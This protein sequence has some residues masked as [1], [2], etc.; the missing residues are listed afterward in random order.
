LFATRMLIL[1]VGPKGA[2]KSHIGRLLERSLDTRFFHVEPL[3]M[4][5]HATCRAQGREPIIPEGIARVHPFIEAALATHPRVSVETTGG[6]AEI[7]EDLMRIGR[8][9]GL[10]LARIAAPVE[11][12]LTRIEARDPTHQIPMD[13]SMIRKVHEIASA[14]DLPFDLTI[15]NTAAGETEILDAFR[16]AIED[17]GDARQ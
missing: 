17:R 1:L 3:W 15:D 4:D 2:G 11:T 8:R 5:Y 14:I 7:L 9:Y 6:S 16:S 10:L 12:C 13:P